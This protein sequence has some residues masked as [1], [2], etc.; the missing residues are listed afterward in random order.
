MQKL[1]LHLLELDITYGVWIREVTKERQSRKNKVNKCNKEKYLGAVKDYRSGMKVSSIARRY[2]V[3]R[4]TI[5]RWLRK[6]GL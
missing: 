6:E 1:W 2:S 5:Y 4:D 3:K